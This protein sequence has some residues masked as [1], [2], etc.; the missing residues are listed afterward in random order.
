MGA[1]AG[2]HAEEGLERSHFADGSQLIQEIVHGELA[3][4]HF[5]LEFEGLL[6]IDLFLGFFDEGDH[7]THTE[8]AIGHAVRVEF[9]QSVDFFAYTDE[10]DGFSGDGLGGESGAAARVG[11]GF[12]KDEAVEFE[13]FVK[14]FGGID[15]VLAG[16]G[17]DDEVDLMGGEGAID[18]AKLV[19]QVIVD[20]E[21][22]CGIEDEHIG[23]GLSGGFMGVA[24][25]F[26]GDADGFAIFIALF[27]L[28]VEADRARAGD[29]GLDLI[30]ECA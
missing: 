27:R 10:F 21:A 20:V 17:V 1:D 16:H 14:S 8:D 11:V 6:F 13:L 3:L 2:Q 23:T 22:T 4:L 26:D 24:A 18:L 19:H 12:R 15:G 9:L 30:G 25:D 5:F 29:I 7:V 28:A